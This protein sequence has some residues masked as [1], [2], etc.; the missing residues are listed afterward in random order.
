MAIGCVGAPMYRT[1]TQYGRCSTRTMRMVYRGNAI[2]RS[3]IWTCEPSAANNDWGGIPSTD[4]SNLCALSMS[5]R[6]FYRQIFPYQLLS[7]VQFSNF[8]SIA[9]SL[10]APTSSLLTDYLL[11]PQ[12]LL[13]RSLGILQYQCSSS[14]SIAHWLPRSLT[15]IAA[16]DYQGSDVLNLQR[17]AYFPINRCLL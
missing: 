5:H 14:I 9:V 10:R 13:T 2:L 7:V 15:P 16:H 3:T 12:L 8:R 11:S 1:R 4:N 6:S 17:Y